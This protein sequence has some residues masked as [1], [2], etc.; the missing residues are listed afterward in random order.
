MKRNMTPVQQTFKIQAPLT[1]SRSL[2]AMCLSLRLEALSSQ[3]NKFFV[4]IVRMPIL[5]IFFASPPFETRLLKVHDAWW[6][7][8]CAFSL[9]LLRAPRSGPMAANIE[10][11]CLRSMRQHLSGH[12]FSLWLEMADWHVRICRSDARRKSSA[13]SPTAATSAAT[14][15]QAA[16][17]YL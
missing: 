11:T 12:S 16:K 4:F 2:L 1:L 5:H 3:Q 7:W 9:L 8:W 14:K 6:W 13:S 10:R 17:T 15:L